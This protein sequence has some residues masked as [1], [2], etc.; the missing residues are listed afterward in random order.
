MT[1]TYTIG[2]THTQAALSPGHSH[3][4][5]VYNIIWRKRGNS[6][7]QIVKDNSQE[8]PIVHIVNVHN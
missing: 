4:F 1:L 3:D 5:N 2:N 8:F 6:C 7:L